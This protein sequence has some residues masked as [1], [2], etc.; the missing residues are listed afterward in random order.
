MTN[1]TFSEIGSR[2]RLAK[3]IAVIAHV[4]PDGDA[5]GSTLALASVLREIGKDAVSCN[6]DGVPSNLAFLPGS[7]TLVTPGHLSGEFDLV[8]VLDTSNRVRAGAEALARLKGAA[9]WINIDHHISNEGYGDFVYVD[10][11]A[12]ATGQI[13]F[14]L[15]EALGWPLTDVARDNLYVAIS[16]DTGSFQYPS[17]TAR[18]YEIGASLARAGADIG[19][20]NSKI[21]DSYPLRRIEVLRELLNDLKLDSDERC[22]SW[23]LT[24]EMK[25]RLSVH[26]EDTENLINLLRGIDS[27]IVAVFF[28]EL[29]D[30]SIR[31]SMRSKDSRADVSAVCGC[32]GG[33]GHRLAA[34]A[35]IDGE[36]SEIQPKVLKQIHE[37]LTAIQA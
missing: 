25:D 8:L 3:R 29:R 20:L 21:Y 9:C 33:G 6:E 4:R 2:I 5:I 11:T 1:T 31:V 36:L 16:T 13:V 24:M 19:E 27:V 34:G 10:E 23:A 28:E 18:T 30:G 7:R 35:R 32:F 14:E 15:V 12:P 37:T 26:P 17:T 22:A